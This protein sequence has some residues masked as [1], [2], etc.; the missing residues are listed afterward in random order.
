M[1]WLDKQEPNLVIYVFFGT[2][3]SFT[4]EQIQEIATV[5]EKSKHKFIWVL[6]DANK[7]GIFNGNEG[8]KA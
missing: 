8:K 2:T 7:G 1:E 6:G 4:E 3:T 5:L